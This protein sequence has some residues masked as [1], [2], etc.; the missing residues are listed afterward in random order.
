LPKGDERLIDRLK[1]CGFYLSFFEG[2]FLLPN[3]FA[4][5]RQ[6]QLPEFFDFVRNRIQGL[7]SPHANFGDSLRLAMRFREQINKLTPEE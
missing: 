6:K 4:R 3:L 2:S 1:Q 7:F 5:L